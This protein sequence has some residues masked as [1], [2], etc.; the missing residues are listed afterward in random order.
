MRR[1]REGGSILIGG[2]PGKEKKG[3]EGGERWKEE[4][5]LRSRIGMTRLLSFLPIFL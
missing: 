1:R 5:E 3:R 2:G 4:G